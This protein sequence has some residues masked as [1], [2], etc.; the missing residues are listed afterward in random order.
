MTMKNSLLFVKMFFLMSIV[1]FIFSI[2][3]QQNV[4]SIFIPHS[5]HVSEIEF[6]PDGTKIALLSWAEIH[7]LDTE[8]WDTIAVITDVFS[9]NIAWHPNS[10]L[11]AGVQGGGSERI[12]IWEA[13]TGK[14]VQ[15]FGRPYHSPWDSGLTPQP[16]T[17][18]WHPDGAIIA[19]D[20][21]M[22]YGAL[23][24]YPEEILL[25]DVNNR[26]FLQRPTLI[27]VTT[28]TRHNSTHLSWSHSGDMLLSYGSDDLPH[29]PRNYMTETK[30]YI[31]DV[32]NDEVLFTLR[33]GVVGWSPDDTM[34]ASVNSAQIT[35]WSIES[36]EAIV[37]SD[38]GDISIFSVEWH[39]DL[40]IIASLGLKG[41]I[42]IWNI[43]TSSL[44]NK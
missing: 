10:E 20:A 26:T 28:T 1:L 16:Q 2:K 43:E 42:Y 3:A 23:R 37:H 31:L 40:P 35:I 22:P 6:S 11:I 7:I 44:S 39:P 30:S 19:T 32:E 5:H 14:L 12:L 21:S 33:G 9:N 34:I 17:I 15:E 4:R 27:E 8:N 38:Q 18:S 13:N 41:N 36:Q 29:N 24:S 25:W